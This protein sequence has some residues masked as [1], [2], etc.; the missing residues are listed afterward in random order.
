MGEIESDAQVDGG[1]LFAGAVVHDERV[2]AG[3]A[4]AKIERAGSAWRGHG[5][6]TVGEFVAQVGEIGPGHESQTDLIGA[7]AGT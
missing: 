4:D 7:G 6:E 5:E 2:V 1:G 3:L